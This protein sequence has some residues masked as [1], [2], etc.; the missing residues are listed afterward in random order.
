MTRFDRGPVWTGRTKAIAAALLAAQFLA[1]YV[2]GARELLR[3]D[4]HA[5]FPPIAIT[6]AVPVAA[7]LGSYALAP[8]FRRFVLAQDVRVLT[9]LQLWRVVGFAFL[10]LYAFGTLPGL[11]ALPAGAGDV[12]VGIAAFVV[13]RRLIERPDFARSMGFLA[14]HA[15]GLADFAVAI[16]TAGL[17]GGALPGLIVG[18]VTSAPMEVWP[19]NIFP[20]FLVPLFI[21]LHLGVLLKVAALRRGRGGRDDP[22]LAR[23]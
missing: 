4:D 22:A 12:A 16:L 13:V 8:R 14:F 23:A 17:A 11:F 10:A 5:L 9:L 2:I 3:S 15:L 21:I 19:L 1:A 7:F 6:A 20:S 18:G